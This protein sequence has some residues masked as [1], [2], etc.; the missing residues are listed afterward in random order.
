MTTCVGAK[1]TANIK[2]SSVA[3]DV[4]G[5][6]GRDMLERLL[7]GES[8][9]DTLSERARG[10]LLA[11]LPALREALDGRVDATHRT[12]LRHLLDHIALL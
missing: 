12:L 1:E 8:S 5:K 6:S 7:A 4:M 9:A 11:K 2:L 10:R 3:T